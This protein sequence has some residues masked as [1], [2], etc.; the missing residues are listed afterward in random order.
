MKETR[1]TVTDLIYDA[2]LSESARIIGL[3]VAIEA[4]GDEPTEIPYDDFARILK[5]APSVDTIARHVRQLVVH[6]YIER[7]SGG[8]G[9]PRFAWA[10]C[11][12]PQKCGA[13]KVLDDSTPQICGPECSLYSAHMRTIT[14]LRPGADHT[15][16]LL[17]PGADHTAP[18]TTTSI[19]P[20]PP[21]LDARAREFISERESLVDTRKP[22]LDYVTEKVDPGKHLAYVHT[23][24]GII[25]ESDERLWKSRNQKETV[26]EGRPQII[27]GCLNELRQSDEIGRYFPG[28]PGDIANLQSK[29][30]YKV[31]SITDAK[32]DAERKREAGATRDQATTSGR[33]RGSFL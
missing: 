18:T 17:R 23:V 29:I 27:A 2:R 30:R 22:L 5:E 15:A 19:P 26:R 28:P 33:A 12:T 4:S 8:R 20:P 9:S 16:S 3:H 6:G 7:R 24:A 25:E 13:N 32:R 31:R 11:S 1:P 14:L 21:P 10:P